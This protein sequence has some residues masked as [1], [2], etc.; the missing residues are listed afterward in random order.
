MLKDCKAAELA[1]GYTHRPV[2]AHLRELGSEP[3]PV[4]LF[5]TNLGQEPAQELGLLAV[6]NQPEVRH[7]L[8]LLRPHHYQA[9]D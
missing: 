2:E 5:G 1:A 4:L 8:L 3:D 7:L 9:Q 6:V